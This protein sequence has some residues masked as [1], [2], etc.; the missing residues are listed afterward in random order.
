VLSR[1]AIYGDGINDEGTIE[2]GTL[3]PE[4]GYTGTFMLR[5]NDQ[6][7]Q[8]DVTAITAEPAQVAARIEPFVTTETPASRPGLYRLIVHIDPHQKPAVY[9]GDRRGKLR[10]TFA[11][12]RIKLLDLG[13]EFV[14]VKPKSL[15]GGTGVAAADRP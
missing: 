9:K 14:V 12:P 2:A 13:V 3:D 5:V 15:F 6:E 7:P 8:L 1:L 4:T 11:H 10:I